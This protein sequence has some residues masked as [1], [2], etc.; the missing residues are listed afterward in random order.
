MNE[1]NFFIETPERSGKEIS[2][3]MGR[4]ILR[5]FG[6]Q[7][8]SENGA[9]Y[10]VTTVVAQARAQLYFFADFLRVP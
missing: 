3:M 8:D 4:V 6:N 5:D 2:G 1:M 9:S 10:N 7:M